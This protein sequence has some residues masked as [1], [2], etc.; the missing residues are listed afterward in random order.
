MAILCGKCKQS[1]EDDALFCAKCGV[2]LEWAT[3]E[4][5]GTDD[6]APAATL[7]SDL[8]RAAATPPPRP[9]QV[10]QSPRSSET[11]FEAPGFGVSDAA[12]LVQ[13]GQQLA[14][15]Q[16][17][18]DLAGHLRQASA[19]LSDQTIPVA[20]VGEFKRGKSTLINALLQQAFCPTDDDVVTAVPT[21]L[22]YGAEL[23]VTAYVE[24]DDGGE[25]RPEPMPVEMLRDLVSEA[26]STGDR[27]RLRS[28]VVRTPH[29][30][31][32][33]GLCLVDT[34]GVGGLESAHGL[35]TL[36][37][38]DSAAAMLFVT[39]A[40]Q[41]LTGPE[42]D[43][44]LSAL[45]R[46]PTAAV[47]VTKTDLYPEW[48][49]IV[50]LNEGHLLRAG[51]DLP[52]LPISS[53]L[54][55]G[56][57][58]D[59]ALNDESHF[60]ALVEW[61]AGTVRRHRT[62]AVKSTAVQDVRFVVG[63]IG[64]EVEA[65][66]AVLQHPQQAERVVANLAVASNRA[67][68]LASPSATWQQTLNDRV[69]DL[70]ADIMHDLQ[71]RL[72]QVL[73]DAEAVIDEG[74]PKEAWADIEVWLRRQ[75]V[76]GVVANYDTL[77]ARAE[78]LARDVAAQFDLEAGTPMQVQ[79]TAPS[80]NL[81]T[82]EFSSPTLLMPGGRLAGMLLGARSAAVVPMALFGVAASIGL[83]PFA[84]PLAI[85][86]GAGIGTKIIRDERQRQVAYRRQQAKASAGKYLDK[87]AFVIGKDSGDAL[88]RTQR[89]LRDEFQIRAAAIHRSTV[90]ALNAAEQ[91]QRI[92]TQDRAARAEKLAVQS[93]DLRQLLDQ[94]AGLTTSEP[95]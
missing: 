66:R 78:E 4:P 23:L 52:V 9:A 92:P 81:A 89:Q 15:E 90:L 48:R 91:A 95:R 44:L 20:V 8:T 28:V 50:E 56:A 19:R 30:M 12:A 21:L 53:F 22:Q 17:R 6:G 51:L 36:S 87:V 27:P 16:N 49:R 11:E 93:T 29:R 45:H 58:Q 83:A 25:P 63:E 43:F 65:E 1:N 70:V 47:V 7:R 55:M 84:A 88:R 86:L 79:T 61:L 14:E 85:A 67:A 54:R 41:E 72:R 62:D 5:G 3:L 38:L 94:T 77:A 32:R 76:T 26:G 24:S 71:D 57:R 82:I 64:R 75:V 35:I 59:P 34:P 40:S 10:R 33:S 42:L 39:D 68:R 13:R 31:L 69:Q 37:A 46:C 60:A 18:P 74:D 80:A 2:F 73:R